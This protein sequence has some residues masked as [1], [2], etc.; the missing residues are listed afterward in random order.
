MNLTVAFPAES[1][2]IFFNVIAQLA[3][4]RKVVNF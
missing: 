2:E 4:R 3:S 1:D